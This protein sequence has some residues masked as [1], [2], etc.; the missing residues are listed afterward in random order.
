MQVTAI[1]KAAII[2]QQEIRLYPCKCRHASARASLRADKGF[3]FAQVVGRLRKEQ[4]R[5]LHR[6]DAYASDPISLSQ[7]GVPR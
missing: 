2:G 1:A 5:E 3:V 4:C 6:F 7:P